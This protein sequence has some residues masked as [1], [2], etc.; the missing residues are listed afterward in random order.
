MESS[1]F[2]NAGANMPRTEGESLLGMQQIVL[3]AP[4]AD[5]KMKTRHVNLKLSIIIGE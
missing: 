1:I 5:I 3:R 2:R 4:C